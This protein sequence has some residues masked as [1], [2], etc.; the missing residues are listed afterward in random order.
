MVGA[1]GI[2]V[3]TDNGFDIGGTSNKAYALLT[4]GGTTKIYSINL[5]TGAATETGAF[6]NSARGF[7]LGL[8]F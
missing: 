4:V 2:D 3:T 7:T 8:G 1:L 6:P 5:T